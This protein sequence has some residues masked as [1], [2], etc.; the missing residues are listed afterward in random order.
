MIHKPFR[1]KPLVKFPAAMLE[2]F[3]FREK[4]PFRTVTNVT[5]VRYVKELERRNWYLKA[6]LK[7]K[8]LQLRTSDKR[9]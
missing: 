1:L 5:Y 8:K 9:D 2:M 4:G 3:V 6:T 7:L